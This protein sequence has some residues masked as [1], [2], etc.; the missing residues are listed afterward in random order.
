[1]HKHDGQP[2][3]DDGVPDGDRVLELR[4]GVGDRGGDADHVCR[5]DGGA[6]AVGGV[7]GSGISVL[8]K[9]YEQTQYRRERKKKK[10]KREK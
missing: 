9:R 6:V 2:Y 3:D 8:G 1:M 4:D 7:C 5:S 10:K